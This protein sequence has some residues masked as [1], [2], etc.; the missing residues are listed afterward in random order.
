MKER[1]PVIYS[2]LL[3]ATPQKAQ[4]NTADE[5]DLDTA[6]DFINGF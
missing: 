6:M 1:H 4:D 5:K 2:E 3:Q